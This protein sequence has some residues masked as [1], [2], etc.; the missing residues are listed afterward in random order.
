MKRHERGFGNN[1]TSV[2]ETS[3]NKVIKFKHQSKKTLWNPPAC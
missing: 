2:K 3:F 1:I